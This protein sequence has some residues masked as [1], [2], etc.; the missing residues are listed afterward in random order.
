MRENDITDFAMDDMCMIISKLG[1]LERLDIQ[2]NLFYRV[3]KFTEL[4]SRL[5]RE[6]I[7]EVIPQINH[8]NV[9]PYK[10]IN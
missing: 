10:L 1:C 2:G 9:H 6:K 8:T 3:R 5:Q 7:R 4:T